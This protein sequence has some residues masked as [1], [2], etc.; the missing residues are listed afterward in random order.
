MHPV[1]RDVVPVLDRQLLCVAYHGA[2]MMS[3]TLFADLFPARSAQL[4]AP[5]L[6]HMF[7]IAFGLVKPMALTEHDWLDTETG[8]EAMGDP[9]QQQ[10]QRREHE[11]KRRDADE[12]ELKVET[13]G[14]N[15][16][17]NFQD[18]VN[19]T[20]W[21]C[22]SAFVSTVVLLHQFAHCSLDLLGF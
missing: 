3:L 4:F 20:A 1:F 14:V 22:D 13:G 10:R 15:K 8:S 17:N 7:G 12:Q 2:L 5:V 21:A 18:K 19:R 6:L 16:E 11:A 9:D